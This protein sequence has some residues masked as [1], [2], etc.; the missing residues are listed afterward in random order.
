MSNTGWRE[1]K[2]KADRP[3]RMMPIALNDDDV[4]VRVR[5]STIE[6]KR[7]YMR[8]YMARRR[9]AERQAAASGRGLDGSRN[10]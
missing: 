7:Q 3:A 9:T 6:R 1:N 5:R 2:T 10:Y 8:E 4:L